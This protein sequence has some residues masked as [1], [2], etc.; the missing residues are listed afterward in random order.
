MDQN[1]RGDKN[2][3]CDLYSGL[4]TV[5]LK[6][7]NFLM[8]F[9]LFIGLEF[10]Y[11]Q[12]GTLFDWLIVCNRLSYLCLKSKSMTDLAKNSGNSFLILI[13][14]FLYILLYLKF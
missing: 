11:S 13:V 3:F 6:L 1:S 12:E 5:C 10:R 14:D 2:L 7:S 4:N 9:M 8:V